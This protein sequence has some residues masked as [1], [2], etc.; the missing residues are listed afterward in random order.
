[1]GCRCDSWGCGCPPG[2]I[3]KDLDHPN[4]KPY[5]HELLTITQV[6]NFCPKCAI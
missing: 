6:F 3:Q 1:M 5:K 2:I 4:L